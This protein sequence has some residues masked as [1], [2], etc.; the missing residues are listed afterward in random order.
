MMW[1]M[2]HSVHQEMA[3]RSHSESCGQW[4][5]GQAE[6]SDKWCSSGVSAVVHPSQ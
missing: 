2:D 5:N 6:T 4:L 1:W 3:G